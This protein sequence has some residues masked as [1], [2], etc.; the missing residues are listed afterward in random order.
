M[1]PAK[2]LFVAL[3]AGTLSISIALYGERWLAEHDAALSLIDRRNESVNSL[4]DIR[5]PDSDGL[6][7]TSNSWAGKVVVLNFWATWCPACLREMPMLVRLQEANPGDRL[8][9]VGIAIDDIASVR[10][11]LTEHK[12]D[13]QILLGNADS[14]KLSK[15]LGN[16]TSGLPFT[17]VF[18]SLGRRVFSHAG[19]ISAAQIRARIMPLLNTESR[20]TDSG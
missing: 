15:R 10:R 19:E 6:E 12:V 3:L 2:V 18:D 8:Q 16:R 5:L 14:V 20:N 4:P 11:F 17:V 1:N 13:Y 7:V 9:V